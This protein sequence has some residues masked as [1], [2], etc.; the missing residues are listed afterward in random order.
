MAIPILLRLVSRP[1]VRSL[2]LLVRHTF[3]LFN[4]LNSVALWF[5]SY[6]LVVVLYLIAL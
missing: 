4:N 5:I 2:S 3:L 6:G 1:L